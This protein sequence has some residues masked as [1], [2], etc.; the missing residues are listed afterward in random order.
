MSA[1]ERLL[2]RTLFRIIGAFRPARHYSPREIPVQR[3]KRILVV[4]QHDQLGDLLITTPAL[5]A[6]RRQFPDA[7]IGVVVRE[8]TAPVMWDNPHVDEIIVFYEKFRK[9]NV[10]MFSLFL[11][12]LRR[13]GGY[14]C[15]VVLNT[16]SRSV[17]SDLIA[18][19]SKAKY[20]IGPGH[21]SLD[22]SLPERIYNVIT[23]RSKQL[24]PEILHNLDIMKALGVQPDGLEYDLSLDEDEEKEADGIYHELHLTGGSLK[25]GVHFGTLDESRRFPLHK[26]AKV[27]DWMKANVECEVIIIIG[28]NEVR[29]R[30][31]LLRMV[32]SKVSCAPLMS[33]RVAAAFIRRMNLFLCNDTGTLHIASAMR[34]PTVSFHGANDPAA[35]KPPHERHIG[36]R[37]ADHRITSITV[38]QAI[39]AV[40]TSVERIRETPI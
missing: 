12:Q 10:Q 6:L 26:L 38:E 1:L 7:Y 4:R 13:D 9:W 18:V 32:R 35:W 31:D 25:I 33:I 24:Q 8:Y 37:A 29:L 22:P 5:R 15:A 36:V 19:L 20:I 14:D 39:E 17:S 11:D 2:K 30:D 40:R 34:V 23:P 3:L 21:L 27:I 28:P 16:V